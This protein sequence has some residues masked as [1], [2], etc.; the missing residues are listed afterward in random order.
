MKNRFSKVSRGKSWIL[1]L[2]AVSGVASSC[3]DEYLLDDEKPPQLSSSI[4]EKLQEGQYSNYLRLLSDPDVNNAEDADNNRGWV[5]VLSK[6]G[7]KTVFVADDAAW[8]K[9]FESNAQLAKSDPWSNATC[10]ENL[11]AAQKKLLI[12]TSMLNNAMVMENLS[13]NGTSSSSRGSLLR[14]NTD[15]ETTDTITFISGDDLPINYNLNNKENDYWSRFRTENGGNGIYLVTDS[16]PSMMIHFTNEYLTRNRITNEDFEIISN[17]SR[18]TSDVHINGHR[19]INQDDVCENGYVNS[20]DGVM[21]PLASMAEVLRTNGRTR[22]FSH[23]IDRWSAPFYSATITRAYANIM[24][25]KGIEWKDSIFVKRYFSERSFNGD[26]LN[27][28]PEGQDFQDANASQVTLKFD[29]AWNAYYPESPTPNPG[30]NMASM[31]VPT[32]DVLWEYFSQNGGGWQLIQT[33]CDPTVTYSPAHTEEDYLKLFKNIDQIPRSTLRSLINVIMFPNFAESVPSKMTK[34]RDDANE[35]LFYDDDKE[36][37]VGTLLASNGA[38]YLTDRVYG[39]A[40]YTSVTAPAYISNDKQ[41]IRWAIYYGSVAGEVSFPLNINYYAYLKA[42][43]S[44]FAFFMP[45][46]DAMQYLYDPISFNSLQPRVMTLARKRSTAGGTFP[47]DSKMYAYSVSEGTIGKRITSAISTEETCNRLKDLL[48]SHTFVL[49]ALEEIDTDVD[50]YYLSKIGSPIRVIRDKDKGVITKVQGGFQV[51]NEANGLQNVNNGITENKVKDLH[52]Q[53][54]GRTYILDSPIVSTY[55]SVYSILTDNDNVDGSEYKAFYDLCVPN[56]D[57]IRA[58]GLVDEDKS[59]EEQ[60][61]EERKYNVFIDVSPEGT[62][63]VDHNISFFN[64][65]RYTAFIPTNDAVED[66]INNQN[67]PTWKSIEEFYKNCEKEEG[68]ETD[69]ANRSDS[70]KLQTMITCLN[71]FVRYHFMDNSVFVDQSKIT[72]ND[73]VTASFDKDKGLF[74][75]VWI[76]RE[77]GVLQVKD[78]NGGDWLT[79]GGKYNVMARDVFCNQAVQNQSMSNKTITTSSFVVIHQIPGVL[80]HTEVKDGDFSN[81]WKSDSDCRKYLKRYA[82]K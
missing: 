32:D 61:V 75:K 36:H 23:M 21:K 55:R 8:E 80:N 14:R 77:G 5:D 62:Y 51:E 31:Y 71:N 70:L 15:V 63:A 16:T 76:Q 7:S 22:I 17:Q 26:P 81:L 13:S 34:L 25:S 67:L 33:F 78:A 40:D 64:N 1:I 45:D 65:Y 39:P 58:C 48:E 18:I 27:K 66:A 57:I 42:M 69:I 59:D 4:Y 10:Y 47:I 38:I 35:Q 30:G 41:V 74:N 29:P 82:I 60:E 73:R 50:E 9:F 56:M 79:V 72:A 11:S 46:D 28:D 3:K 20:T 44:R 54:N 37:I 52:K 43:K 2:L 19:L 49:D 68:S 6:T 12:H 24:A 53:L